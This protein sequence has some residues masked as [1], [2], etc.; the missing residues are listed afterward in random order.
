VPIFEASRALE[1]ET[2]RQLGTF[3]VVSRVSARGARIFHGTF[4]D[5][6]KSNG[7]AR[8]RLVACASDD[9]VD[10]LTASPTV[11]IYSNH[12]S[13][14]VAACRRDFE[15]KFRDITMAF[16]QSETLISRNAYMESPPK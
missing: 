15:V 3:E 12:V 6:I 8:S 14:A 7:L 13:F 5:V 1:L 4:V 11:Q 16:L 10:Y 2:H 9:N